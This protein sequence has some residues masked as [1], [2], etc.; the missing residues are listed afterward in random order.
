MMRM[1]LVTPKS[2]ALHR[3]DFHPAQAKSWRVC[4]G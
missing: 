4:F 2:V 1:I 3:V